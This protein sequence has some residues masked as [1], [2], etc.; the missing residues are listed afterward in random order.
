MPAYQD[1]WN[2]NNRN[3]NGNCNQY[4]NQNTLL[5]SLQHQSIDKNITDTGSAINREVNAV[6]RHLSA[7]QQSIDKNITDTGSAIIREVNN[8]DK[9]LIDGVCKVTD[10]VFASTASVRDNVNTSALGLRDAIERNAG[11]TNTNLTT[12]FQDNADRARDIQVSIERT[13]QTGTHATE[14]NASLLLQSVERNAGETRYTN[15]VTDSANRQASNDL[16]RDIIRDINKTSSDTINQLNRNDTEILSSVQSTGSAATLA[17]TTNGYEVRTLVNSNASSTQ[18]LINTTAAA[19]QSSIC[20]STSGIQ[21]AIC[22]LGHQSSQQY[23]SILLEQQKSKELLSS[24]GSQQYASLL[25]EQQK[26]KEHVS[27][28][29]ADAKY[30]ALRNKEGLSAQLAASSADNKYEALK[31]TQSIQSQLAECCCEIKTRIDCVG[32]KVDDTLRTLDTQRLRDALNTA[33]SEVNLLKV[34]EKFTSFDRLSCNDGY[35][36]GGNRSFNNYYSSTD[37]EN[38]G[39]GPT[40]VI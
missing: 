3:G 34:A 40:R 27:L 25:L 24:Q 21:S 37:T 30:E 18:S 31:N 36:G 9:H 22:G 12:S 1:Y 5:N 23:S 2:G 4:D 38:I 7:Q 10:S 13:A 17:T 14:R 26:V 20:A 35:G 33:N 39:R 11:N 16:A 32:S 8:V 15:A 19:V 29:L 28:Q 6:E